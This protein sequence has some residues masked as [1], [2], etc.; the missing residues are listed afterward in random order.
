MIEPRYRAVF[1][2]CLTQGTVIGLLFAYGLL[3]KE[4]E[5]EF[6]WS[7]TLL[8]SCTSLAFLGMGILAI[9][10][11]TLSDK[12]GPRLVL[13]FTGVSIGIGFSLMSMMTSP[14]H[15]FA[16][17]GIF[18]SLGM[19]THDVVTLSIVARWFKKRRGIM[20]A[21]VK[22]GTAIGQAVVPP[23]MAILILIYG[24]RDAVLIIGTSSAILLVMAGLNTSHPKVTKSDH[25]VVTSDGMPFEI[26]KKTKKFWALC[27]IQ[28]MII[29]TLLAIPVHIAVHGMDLGMSATKASGLLS[30]IGISSIAGRISIGIFFDR[31]G[32]RGSFLLCLLPLAFSLFGFAI[33]DT[34]THLFAMVAI[35]GFGHGGF[36]TVTSPVVANLFGTKAHG[37]IFGTILFFGSIG[38][39]IGPIVVGR[40]FDVTG[41]YQSA[42]ITLGCLILIALSLSIFLKTRNSSF[43]TI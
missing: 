36:F 31:V 28:L 1:G 2:A 8:S 7:R 16:I 25:K 4:F 24:W 9:L 43:T 22:V 23:I 21:V 17:F 15:L 19:G 32:G 38:G 39:S 11:G 27:L 18:V 42:F 10:G 34:H 33:V 14:W 37:K 40:V 6:G 41:S 30:I 13:C 20:T 29:T 26:V 5:T 35:Y 12:Y 3:I